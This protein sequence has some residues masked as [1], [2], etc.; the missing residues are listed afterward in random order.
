MQRLLPISP[1][2]HRDL[3]RDAQALADGGC[4]QMI[5]REPDRSRWQLEEALPELRQILPG[6][7]LHATNVNAWRFAELHKTGLHLP[8]HVDPKLWRGRFDGL[9]G[10][11]CHS[12]EDLQSAADA[13]LDYALLSPIYSPLSKKDSRRILGPVAAAKIQA[14]ADL[15]IFGLGGINFRRAPSC[16]GLYGVASMGYLFGNRTNRPQLS[17]RAKALLSVF[18]K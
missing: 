15:P 1:N 17:S 5:L 16:L 7:I 11:S 8:S 18:E 3:I 2:S 13:G 6:L 9:L 10:M 12:E 14:G 4:S